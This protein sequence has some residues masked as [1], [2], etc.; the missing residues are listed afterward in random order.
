MS[1][2]NFHTHE[3]ILKLITKFNTLKRRSNTSASERFKD[4]KQREPR[5]PLSMVIKMNEEKMHTPK[6]ENDGLPSD[7]KSSRQ[8]NKKDKNP[9]YAEIEKLKKDLEEKDKVINDYIDQI[10]RRQA[11][12][13]NY[14]KRIEKQQEHTAQVEAE[15]LTKKLL[16]IID[17]LER[18][19]ESSKHNHDL[20]TLTEG[21]E[22]THKLM[23]SILQK[24]GLETIDCKGKE[25]D[26]NLHEAIMPVES[27]DH[28]DN[29]IYEELEKGYTFKNKLI[30]PAKVKVV[31]N[32]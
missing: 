20:K 15:K 29:T 16:C 28:Q 4:L 19:L 13:E 30:R 32:K 27:Q 14:R 8:D 5:F 2:L 22:M 31:K 12:F 17:N 6:Q 1:N 26:P 18:A 7:T 25:F 23:L 10:K 9:R 21:I 3:N 11:E 24:E